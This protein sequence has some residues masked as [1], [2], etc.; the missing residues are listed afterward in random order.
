MSALLWAGVAGPLLFV[1]L[2]LRLGATRPNYSPIYTFVSQLSLN[3]GGWM[4]IATFIGSGLLVLLFGWA[5]SGVVAH[6]PAA[7]LGSLAVCAVGVG[8]IGLGVC[9]DDP[10]LSY[11]PGAP[12]GIDGPVSWRG[13]GH[14]I[15]GL[16]VMLG[17]LTAVLTFAWGFAVKGDVPLY[18]YCI[19]TAILFPVTY[20]A[21]VA[22][23]LASSTPGARFAGIAGLIQRVSLI[24]GLLW[25]LV[26]AFRFALFPA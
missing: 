12:P 7:P 2:F 15:S 25:I 22:S 16:V 26:L 4:Q 6:W 17:V 3:G 11:P 13:R 18:A 24:I 10:W 14:V 5:L 9:V 20:V 1:V 23:A 19:V 21:A 8:L